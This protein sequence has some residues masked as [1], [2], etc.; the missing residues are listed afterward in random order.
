VL[1]QPSRFVQG[2]PESILPGMQVIESG[3]FR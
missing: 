2:L 1:G 3:G